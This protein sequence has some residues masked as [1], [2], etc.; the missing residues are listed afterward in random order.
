[1]SDQDRQDDI[2]ALRE[3]LD[4]MENFTDNDQRA[5]YLLS[6]NWMRERGAAAAARAQAELERRYAPNDR[7]A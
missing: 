2:R 7:D 5:R 6:S 3:L 4:L 1:M